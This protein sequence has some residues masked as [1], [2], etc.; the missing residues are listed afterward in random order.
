MTVIV[1]TLALDYIGVL[2]FGISG[3]LK[4]GQRDMDVFGM[5]VLALI[6]GVGGGTIR[7]VL[8]GESPM[9]WLKDM[10]YLALCVLAT[11]GVLVLAPRIVQWEKGLLLFDAIGLGVFT[12]IGTTKGVQAGLPIPACIGLGC[13]TGIGGGVLRDVLALTRPIVLHR[14]IY[15]LASLGG[16]ALWLALDYYGVLPAVSLLVAGLS[17]V[18][19]RLLAVQYK[20]GLPSLGG[21]S[22]TNRSKSH[23]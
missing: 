15:A 16:A 3:A 10:N 23:H 18:T 6:T 11:V 5:F 12:V 2:V 1:I 19:I 13:V 17:V 20:W 9:F 4:A 22:R 8:L 21:R 14:E 7:D